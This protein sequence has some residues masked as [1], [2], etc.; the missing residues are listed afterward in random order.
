VNIISEVNV[1]ANQSNVIAS[2]VVLMKARVGT[3]FSKRE[4]GKLEIQ[5]SSVR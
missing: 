3:Q 2:M 5:P 4:G 1:A